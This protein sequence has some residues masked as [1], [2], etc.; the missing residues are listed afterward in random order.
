MRWAVV[1]I[2]LTGCQ[3][4]LGDPENVADGG[5]TLPDAAS[6]DAPLIDAS[7]PVP[8]APL[9]DAQVCDDGDVNVEDPGTGHCYMLFQTIQTWADASAACAA[10]GP[11]THLAVITTPEENALISPMA[12]LLDVWVGSTDAAIE[13]TWVWVNAEPFVWDN[14]RDGEP[15]DANGEDCMILEGELNG[16]WDDRDCGNTYAYVCERE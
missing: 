2:A 7:L 15:N 4:S 14:W 3:A 16:S 10:I 12:G 6:V 8:D 13:M 5:N 9:P 1:L 11:T